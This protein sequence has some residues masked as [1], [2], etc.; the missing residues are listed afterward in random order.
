MLKDL[1]IG[2]DIVL[3][4]EADDHRLER[5]ILGRLVH[6]ASGRAY[7]LEYCPPKIP[8]TDDVHI[9]HAWPYI[10]YTQSH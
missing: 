6:P 9:Y 5:R 4:L 10:F 1:G 3:S 8:M 2:L 7:H